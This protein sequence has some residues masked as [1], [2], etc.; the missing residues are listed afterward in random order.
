V[1]ILEAVWENA[2]V[3]FYDP[4]MRGVDW[5]AVRDEFLPRAAACGSDEQ[6]LS[7]LREML[8]RLR[9]SH[10][11]LY[12]EE[13]WSWRGNTLPFCFDRAADR[14]FVRY[15]L[16][17]HDSTALAALKFGDEIVAVDGV[18][19]NALRPLTLARLEAVKGNPNFG[20][21]GS[22]AKVEIRRGRSRATVEVR[23]VARPAGFEAVL[24][25]RPRPNVV[26]LRLLTLASR[27]LSAT[28]LRQ[29]WEEVV[30][31]Q[32]VILDLRN[33]VGGDPAVSNFIA[34]SLLGPGKPL[35]RTVPRPGSEYAEVLDR[36]DP[37]APRFR[38]R[39][40]VI[41]NSN[42]ESQPEILAAICKEYGC[43]RIVGERTAG[44]FNGWTIAVSLPY[45]FAKYA[46]PYTRSVSPHGIEYEGRG[47]E[48]D[49]P[50][51]NM[52]EDFQ[53]GRDRP[54]EAALRYV[55]V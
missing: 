48:P 38:G 41:T 32:G 42:T 20:P 18:S 52:V 28:R 40:A 13:E 26:C 23:R 9:N 7:L 16:R 43:G 2:R 1:R 33:C 39:V 25:E 51:L 45:R 21:S 15:V 54:L 14:V 24:L 55:E 4:Q 37:E 44:A 19:A 22:S 5:K 34:G 36:S 50:A 53:S 3:V 6:L 35:C 31:A 47:V 30:A 12:S 11:F 17:N 29:V 8:S 46:L 10:I 49:E 27:E